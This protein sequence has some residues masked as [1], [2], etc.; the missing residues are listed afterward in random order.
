MPPEGGAAE[1]SA[2]FGDAGLSRAGSELTAGGVALSEIAAAAGTPCFVYNAN[3]I[4]ERFHALSRAL[5]S[6]LADARIHFAVKANSNL[7]VLRI[8]RDL[9]AG[10]D[11]VSLGELRRALAAGFAPGH[12]VFSG[13]GKSRHEL[14]EAIAAGVGQINVES[15]EELELL[16]RLAADAGATVRVGVRINP[17]VTTGTHPYISTGEGGIKFGVP[18][19]QMDQVIRLVTTGRSLQLVAVAVHIGSQ[20]TERAPFVATLEKLLAVVSL[21]E[22]SGVR[23]EAV[24]VGGGFGIRYGAEPGIDLDALGAAVRP[25]LKALADRGYRVMLEPGRFLVGSAGLLLTEVLYVKRSGGRTFV[26]VDAGMN[27]LLRPSLYGA[28]HHIVE[29]EAM[30]RDVAPVS[31]VGPV[32]ETG[33]FFAH[34]RPLPAVRAGERLALL[35]AGAYSFTMSSN[36]N[37]RPRA[38]EVIVDGGRFWVAR[39]RETVDDLLRG[40]RVAPPNP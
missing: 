35:G 8:L 32:C 31:V 21:V 36:Y 16:G 3:A 27:D 29:L 25:R 15:L 10:A 37:T 33:D 40:E 11:I 1:E 39:E 6:G 30:G 34:E 20:I 5:L 18:F 4:R 13:V 14:R 9:G 7:G 28:Y 23:L 38:A 19:D 22:A 2:L 12:V 24:D 17:D 26:I